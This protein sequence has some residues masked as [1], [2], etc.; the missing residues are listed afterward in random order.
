MM[1][2]YPNFILFLSVIFFSACLKK[3]LPPPIGN[4][5]SYP[6]SLFAFNSTDF[7]LLNTDANGDYADGSLQRYHV[8]VG[9]DY[10]LQNVV[11]VS[12]HGSEL[13]VSPDSK[14]VVLSF[15]SSQNPTQL[16]F[17][18]YS[19]PSLP[20]LLPQLMLS[21]VGA[22]GKQTIKNLRFFTPT[23]VG[24]P[25]DASNY[26]YLYGTI[27]SYPTDTGGGLNIPARTF[28]AKIAKDFSSSRV[29]FTL[30]Y[31][32]GDPNSLAKKSD[33][34][35]QNVLSAQYMFGFGSPTYDGAHDV[36]LAFP[37]GSMNGYNNQ[38]TNIFPP[39]PD[40]M[41]YFSGQPAANTN[42]NCGSLGGACIQPDFR[43]VSAI[44][45]DFVSILNSEPLN[46]SS[47]FIP[48]GWNKNGIPYAA[49][50][51][52]INLTFPV[53]AGNPDSNS[54]GFQTNFWSSYWTNTDSS[55][56]LNTSTNTTNQYQLSSNN[57]I[58]LA[59]NGTNGAGD[60]GNGNEVFF[61]TGLDKL[62]SNITAIHTA[63]GGI[64]PA[65]ELDFKS[66]ASYQMIDPYNVVPA[67]P[68]SW[69]NGAS[70]TRNAGPL[71]PYMYSRTTDVGGFNSTPTA[72]ADMGVLNFGSNICRPY[73]VRNTY[74]G[75]G[76]LGM[77][78]AWIGASPNSGNNGTYPNASADPTNPSNYSFSWGSGAQR[79]ASV[80]PAGSPY[81]FCA[82][83]LTS[84]ITR[85]NTMNTAPVVN[86][87]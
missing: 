30:S 2:K 34:L 44:A 9:G 24:V 14:L 42:Q 3:P 6:G 76:S 46:H 73:W 77:D 41:S 53:N 79:C 72:V 83:F 1:L 64:N 23:T 80:K 48:M 16:Q 11:S 20:S 45:V 69:L 43:A 71:T 7:L 40:A 52:G 61:I 66:I 8:N 12:P 82:N 32:V 75:V 19:N 29:L 74:G 39:M 50:T 49:V 35:N 15:D 22:G 33:S 5:L 47:Y 38:G 62:K 56:Y 21:F 37:T 63:R 18:N 70:G 81:V 55:C 28:V 10:A 13:A 57:A 17:Y 25:A 36:L 27:L 65:G 84:E 58:L 31:G 26:Y 4:N 54:F 60:S 51:N 67:V 68:A 85:F 87:F 86:P 59:K 78:S